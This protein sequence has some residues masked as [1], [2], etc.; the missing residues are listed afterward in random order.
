M[1]EIVRCDP[2]LAHVL[3]CPLSAI[4]SATDHLS[5]TQR[6]LEDGLLATAIA[7]HSPARRTVGLSGQIWGSGSHDKSTETLSFEVHL[8]H[9]AENVLRG[10]A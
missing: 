3:L 9:V 5:R 6:N 1:S 2:I 8:Q 4:A 10:Q 7:M